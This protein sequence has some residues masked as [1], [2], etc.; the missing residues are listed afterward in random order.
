[1]QKDL[2][3]L[4]KPGPNLPPTRAPPPRSGTMPV[5]GHRPVGSGERPRGP[6]KP[7]GEQLDTFN[8]SP[9]RENRHPR[10]NS[11]SSVMEREKRSER[12]ERTE[13]D[14]ERRRQRRKEREER[15][16][17]EKEKIRNGGK[18]AKKQHGLDLI[19]K[20][21]VTG[22]Y[23]QGRMYLHHSWRVHHPAADLIAQSSTTM[24]PSMPAIHTGIARETREPQCKPFQSDQPIW[25]LVAV[26]R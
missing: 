12:R 20:L 23:G 11:E 14:D 18:P 3:L 6:P 9:K 10:R 15:H 5:S 16:R 7:N 2:S 24:V 17:R 25:L 26:A 21:D 1:M 22:I 4:D 8:S 19:D 13:D